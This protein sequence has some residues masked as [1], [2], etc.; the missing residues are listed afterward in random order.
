MVTIGELAGGLFDALETRKRNDGKEFV[1]LKD[2]SPE[3]MTDAIRK[4]HGDSFPDDAI[5]QFIQQAAGEIYDASAEDED[6]ATDAVY[7][8]E[9]NCYTSNLTAWLDE[10][11]D[12]VYY[13][14]EVLEECAPKDGFQLLAMAQKRQM[15]EVG[16]ALVS[17]LVEHA[18]SLTEEEETA[19]AD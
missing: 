8:M 17:A 1:C 14:T 6:S 19:H 16:T 10:R 11:P 7:E 9:P 15:D 2:D 13:L 4:A 12:R 3:W 18:D 5:Y